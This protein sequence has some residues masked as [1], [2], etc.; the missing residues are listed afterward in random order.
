MGHFFPWV[1][2]LWFLR[3][4]SLPLIWGSPFSWWLRSLT[5][6]MALSYFACCS[7]HF[8]PR[9]FLITTLSPL[10]Q[11]NAC[12]PLLSL[13]RPE[14]HWPLLYVSW[15]S[16]WMLEVNELRAR[17]P[18]LA[19]SVT[20]CPYGQQSPLSWVLWHMR[21]RRV[22]TLWW[23]P[24]NQELGIQLSNPFK[25]VFPATSLLFLS[26]ISDLVYHLLRSLKIGVPVFNTWMLQRRL[27]SILWPALPSHFLPILF[28][29]LRGWHYCSPCI[30]KSR[31]D[32][33]CPLRQAF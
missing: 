18:G 29:S 23:L 28:A 6:M 26:S 27:G 2:N 32:R 1:L 24:T 3:A 12:W 20:V 33:V 19:R 30:T 25:G 13:T 10:S 11:L 4:P 16:W 22:L 8:K 21:R 31:G 5:A 17:G 15:Q 7:P 14:L 9:W